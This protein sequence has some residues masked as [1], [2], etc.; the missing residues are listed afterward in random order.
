VEFALGSV[1]FTAARRVHYLNRRPRLSAGMTMAE[2]AAEHAE[3]TAP[4]SAG[5]STSSEPRPA[6][7]S[8]S[9]SPPNTRWSWSAAPADWAPAPART[10]GGGRPDPRRCRSSPRRCSLLRWCH[11]GAAGSLRLCSPR[12]SVPVSFPTT[13]R[14][15]G[16]DGRSRGRLRPGRLPGADPGTDPG[17]RRR[18]GPFLSARAVRRDCGADPGQPSRGPRRRGHVTISAERRF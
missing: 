14:G 4:T 7:A 3:A 8:P 6:A 10:A 12:W 13:A 1:V 11:R 9:S 5:P 2:L 15:P 17:R 16:G 18:R